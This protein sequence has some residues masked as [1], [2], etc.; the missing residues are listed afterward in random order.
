MTYGHPEIPG[1]AVHMGEHIT[2]SSAA[3]QECRGAMATFSPAGR[4]SWSMPTL[5]R[6]SQA[7]TCLCSVW[8]VPAQHKGKDPNSDNLRNCLPCSSAVNRKE[9]SSCLCEM[10]PFF[11]STACTVSPGSSI[12]RC[13]NS[14]LPLG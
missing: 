11:L 10:F 14:S 13:L 7:C 12:Y 2:I 5:C 3:S 9:L 1:L 6:S 4:Q 8:P